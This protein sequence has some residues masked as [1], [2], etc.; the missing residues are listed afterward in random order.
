M[1]SAYDAIETARLATYLAAKP[2]RATAHGSAAR[3][4]GLTA[5]KNG[6]SLRSARR[7][8]K[9]VETFGS[10]VLQVLRK[11]RLSDVALHALA[12]LPHDLRAD[13]ASRAVGGERIYPVKVAGEVA[14]AQQAAQDDPVLALIAAFDALDGG[15]QRRA[16][17]LMQRRVDASAFIA[18]EDAYPDE[19][20]S[21]FEDDDVFMEIAAN[22]S[23]PNELSPSEL[24][25]V[26]HLLTQ[27]NKRK[28]YRHVLANV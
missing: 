10:E 5:A 9:L 21:T 3:V 14:L 2:K 25:L 22:T 16:A 4:D 1:I 7:E 11:Q 19:D 17:H 13:L 23:A 27:A 6:L 15:Q 18:G 20:S 8:R 28:G 12:D 26:E 24:D